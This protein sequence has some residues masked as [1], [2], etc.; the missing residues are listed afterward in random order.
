MQSDFSEVSGLIELKRCFEHD[1]FFCCCPCREVELFC[2]SCWNW[3]WRASGSVHEYAVYAPSLFAVR[4]LKAMQCQRLPAPTLASWMIAISL[5]FNLFQV[6]QS[7]NETSVSTYQLSNW[8]N[9]GLPQTRELTEE[10]K[11][12][13]QIRA[14]LAH[15]AEELKNVFPPFVGTWISNQLLTSVNTMD[16][17]QFRSSPWMKGCRI[18]RCIRYW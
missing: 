4:I 13:D 2:K 3:R 18:I 11:N 14:I 16:A 6:H 7:M 17:T 15:L 1:I 10:L 5:P 8:A 9:A 12:L